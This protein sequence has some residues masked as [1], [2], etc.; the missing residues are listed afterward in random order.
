MEHTAVMQAAVW[1]GAREQRIETVP[2]PLPQPDELLLRVDAV[3][4]CGS[5]LS[6][7]LGHLSVRDGRAPLIPG[8][9]CTGTVVALGSA[10]AD[11]PSGGGLLPPLNLGQ[12][13]ALNPLLSDG[14]CPLCLRGLE[15]LCLQRTLIGAHR[16]G[17]FAE[18]VA[19][20]ARACYRLP[21]HLDA[22]TGAL[23]E[24]LACAVRA[25]HLAAVDP[26]SSLL[27][28][29]AGPIGL[30]TLAVA[31]QL[32]VRLVAISDVQPARLA[33]ATAWGANLTINPLHQPL[34]DVIQAATDGLGC[35]VAIDAVGVQATRA[36]A[37]QVVRPGGRVILVGLHEDAVTLPANQIVR[38]EISVQGSYSYL[39]T[40]FARAIDLLAAGLLPPVANW[41]RLDTLANLTAC[42]ETLIDQPGDV[43]KVIIQ[44]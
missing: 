20:P 26:A 36:Q 34:S 29:G 25:V 19:V 31:K 30:L 21:E 28:L 17:A 24:P 32:N 16:N 18:Y 4:I 27:I 2:Q 10:A 11:L 41:V 38:S 3:G 44:P 40:T 42:I 9:E 15:Q 5:D 43:V 6:G 12:R 39:P 33:V 7:Y 22:V 13:V 14:T 1:Y 23:A 37:I 35:D 8:H